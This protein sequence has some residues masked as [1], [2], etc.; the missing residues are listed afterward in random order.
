MSDE[1]LLL[2]NLKWDCRFLEMAKL[3]STWSKDPNTQVGAVIVDANRRVVST[4]YNGFPRGIE[5]DIRLS[6]REQKLKL[7]V[8][9]EQNAILFSNNNQPLNNCTIYTYPFMPCSTCAGHIIQVG[10]INRVVSFK[11]NSTNW[12]EHFMQSRKMFEEV[13]IELLELEND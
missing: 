3:I 1:E 6:I 2:H 12:E 4:G 13:D 10:W 11:S 9:A 5:D 7:I 8:H